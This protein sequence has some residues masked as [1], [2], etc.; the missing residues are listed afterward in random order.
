MHTQWLFKMPPL[1]L[2]RWITGWSAYCVCRGPRFGFQHPFGQLTSFCNSCSGSSDTFGLCDI[3]TY[4]QTHNYIQFKII[5]RILKNKTKVLVFFLFFLLVLL[6]LPSSSSSSSCSSSWSSSRC[7][8]FSSWCSFSFLDVMTKP[9]LL[10][11]LFPS[12]MD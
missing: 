4:R 5:K 3:C 7:S 1:R 8:S 12:V 11:L 10:C 9:A 6:L 2:K